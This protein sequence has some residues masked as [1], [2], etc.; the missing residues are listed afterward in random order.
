VSR[1]IFVL[2]KF[3]IEIDMG[4]NENNVTLFMYY[5]GKKKKEKKRLT[6]LIVAVVVMIIW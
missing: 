5:M 1:H 3:S 4:I 2:Q 6:V